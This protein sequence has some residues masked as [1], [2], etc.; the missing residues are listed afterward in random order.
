MRRVFGFS[1]IEAY[2]HLR[3]DQRRRLI[4]RAGP[5]LFHHVETPDAP[6]IKA[7]FVRVEVEFD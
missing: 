4:T 5:G 6:P 1:Q 3:R 7:R 2:N